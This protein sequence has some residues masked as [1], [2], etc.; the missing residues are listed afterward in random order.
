LGSGDFDK[1]S[2]DFY[3]DLSDYNLHTIDYNLQAISTSVVIDVGWK[4]VLNNHYL[5]FAIF[6][7]LLF[8]IFLLTYIVLD[9]R[10]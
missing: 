8:V 3:L 2:W 7:W 5:S 10:T 1:E 6:T 4:I 9:I